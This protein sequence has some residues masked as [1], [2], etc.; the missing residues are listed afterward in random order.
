M[1][2]CFPT[3]C[4]NMSCTLKVLLTVL[5]IFPMMVTIFP[6]AVG[7]QAL[8][9]VA[10]G[11]NSCGSQALKHR[12]NSCGAQTWLLHGMWDLPRSGSNPCLLHWQVDSYHSATREVWEFFKI[13]LFKIL[14][15]FIHDLFKIIGHPGGLPFLGSHRVGHDWSDLAAAAAVMPGFEIYDKS[16]KLGRLDKWKRLFSSIC[17]AYL[18]AVYERDP[19]SNLGLSPG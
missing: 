11:L 4:C 18:S 17:P 2:T 15:S 16:L 14:V 19:L 13:K 9:S 8:V 7:V 12:F 5:F 6:Q 1:H 3:E 10:R